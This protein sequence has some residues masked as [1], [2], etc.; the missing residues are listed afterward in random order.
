MADQQGN[1]KQFTS[2][3]DTIDPNKLGTAADQL[4]TSARMEGA[5]YRQ[6]GEDYKEAGKTL[7]EAIDNHHF[8]NEVSTGAAASAA[9]TN[10]K[11]EEWRQA[12]SQPGAAHDQELQKKFMENSLEP[13]LQQ[14]QDGFST[15]RGQKWALDHADTIRQ[16]FYHTTAADMANITGEQR[17]AD[18]TTQMNQLGAMVAKS[19]ATADLAIKQWNS[20]IDAQAQD[21]TFQTPEN[22]S[23][24]QT[25]RQ[26]G[27]NEIAK[28][29]VKSFADQKN[30]AVAQGLLDSGVHDK[31]I[32]PS[33]RLELGEYIKRAQKDAQSDQ[34][35]AMELQD[36]IQ[37]Q[38]A[39]AVK[40]DII[41]REM[42][43]QPGD[44]PVTNAEIRQNPDL[45]FEDKKQMYQV[46][47]KDD[48][49]TASQSAG[50]ARDMFNNI[51]KPAGDPDKITSLSAINQAYIDGKINKADLDWL[52][53]RF[54]DYGGSQNEN[55]NKDWDTFYKDHLP[56][57]DKSTML[58]NDPLSKENAYKY[59]Q[60]VESKK[61]E[62]LAQNKDPHDLI[63][64]TKPDYLG[65]PEVLKQ[66][67][68]TPS[69][70][71]KA[72]ADR[73]RAAPTSEPKNPIKNV[74][75][76]TNP[77]GLVKVWNGTG[78]ETKK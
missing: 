26:D 13:A 22:A 50:N 54:N 12:A 1:I 61:Q 23:K 70:S 31:N 53:K 30:F 78:W 8:M 6:A 37:K 5:L 33:E 49:T 39:D 9:M 18:V 46:L 17:H 2:P 24:L 64:P 66:F 3:I 48:T 34:L 58:K 77:A 20:F 36:K 51:V 44:K 29:Q 35:R 42:S 68:A 27:L 14:W 41:D 56:Q 38:K 69:E 55:A 52:S 7:G 71:M 72:Q 11:M 32:P 57:I 63:D 10:N 62:Y 74:T 73:M 45:K 76:F 21:T 40:S 65:S 15:E 47:A 16:E 19:P 43:P 67:Q 25:W 75:T 59:Q 60:F 28:V 4:S